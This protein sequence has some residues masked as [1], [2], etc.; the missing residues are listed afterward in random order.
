[1]DI[2]CDIMA[3]ERERGA[4]ASGSVS[5]AVLR[6]IVEL[7][8]KPLRHSVE[9]GSG[10][11]TVLLSQ[12]ADHHLCFTMDEN[13]AFG[14]PVDKTNL[15]FVQQC[16]LFRADKTT[17]VI[18]PTQRTLPNHKFTDLIDLVLI[19]G[20]HGYPFPELD[21]YFLYPHLRAGGVLIV[22]DINIPTIGR[23]AEFLAEDDMFAPLPTE[24]TT[25]F[26]R[27]TLAATF[28]PEADGW[29]EQRFN[30]NR[31]KPDKRSFIRRGL[32]TAA[33]KLAPTL[34]AMYSRSRFA[35]RW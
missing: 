16:P 26:F 23:M 8:P 28:N 5:E 22:D 7:A 10:K 11:T 35:G 6:K 2:V 30:I 15:H 19:D 25:A 33:Q 1:M 9:T 27:R 13:I 32:R 29:T 20:A 34:M 31:F 12:L 18:G 3:Y 14:D 4:P 21:Y 24:G 17:I